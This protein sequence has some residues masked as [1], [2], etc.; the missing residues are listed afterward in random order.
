MPWI[1]KP[2]TRV[3]FAEDY[4]VEVEEGD[5]YELGE[6]IMTLSINKVGD[7]TSGVSLDMKMEERQEV[8]DALE[9]LLEWKDD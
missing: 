2:G 1:F 8:W 3:H 5:G 9:P 4:V 7:E 6:P